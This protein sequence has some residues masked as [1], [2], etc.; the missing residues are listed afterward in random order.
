MARRVFYSFHYI[1]DNWRASQ[2]RQMGAIEGDAPVSD[3]DWEKVPKGGEAAIKKWINDQMAGR[4]C[5]VVLAGTNTAG[6]KWI[7]YEIKKAWD[8]GK[9]VLAIH[10]HNLKNSQ[11]QQAAKG[12]NPL[13]SVT[14]GKNNVALSTIAKSYDPPFSTSTNVYSH[15]KTNLA[16]WVED[17]IKIRN[18]N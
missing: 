6:R 5:V 8:D 12:S 17:A 14:V 2:V 18:A 4:A 13:S 1:P 16:T 9:A 11:E 15:I 7:D 10:I 3:N